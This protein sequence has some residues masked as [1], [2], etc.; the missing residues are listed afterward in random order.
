MNTKDLLR[1]LPKVDILLNEETIQNLVAECGR[2]MVVDCIRE[3]LDR[4]RTMVLSGQMEEAE[5]ALEDF[6]SL[7]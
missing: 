6:V 4:V 3:E 1:K 7:I 2:G 5:G